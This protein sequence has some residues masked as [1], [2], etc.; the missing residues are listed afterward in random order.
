MIKKII[1][2]SSLCSVL[3]IPTLGM[4]HTERNLNEL[5]MR[6]IERMEYRNMPTITPFMTN[7]PSI[8]PMR[9]APSPW[10]GETNTHETINFSQDEYNNCT[11]S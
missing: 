8:M 3:M 2:I 11:I 4:D 5:E 9:T 1:G 6:K 7:M 10:E